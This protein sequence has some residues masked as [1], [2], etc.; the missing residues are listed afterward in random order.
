MVA[1]TRRIAAFPVSTVLL[2]S[3]C[4]ALASASGRRMGDS[5]EPRSTSGVLPAE[6]QTTPPAGPPR[7]LEAG[8]Y[9]ALIEAMWWGSPTFRRQ[10]QRL[11][12]ERE[13]VVTVRGPWTTGVDPGIR[14]ST[15][16]VRAGHL[17]TARILLASPV[18]T[19][20][21]IAH[22]IEHIIEYLDQIRLS[23]HV[24]AG[25]AQ[26]VREG[27]ESRRAV[28]IGLR[29]AREVDDDCRARACDERGSR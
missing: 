21:L 5:Q 6:A 20:E 14:A 12:A 8:L 2:L 24:S 29:V 10:C 4:S 26:G 19:V 3:C 22:E 13:L 15:S 28:A 25:N 18:D 1:I 7:N 16:I 27:F 9:D 23:D 17:I 11:A